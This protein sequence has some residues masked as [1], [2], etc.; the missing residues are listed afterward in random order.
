MGKLQTLKQ[1]REER[2]LSQEALHHRTGVPGPYIS[3]TETGARILSVEN[4]R[5]LER[6]LDTRI[7]WEDSLSQFDRAQILHS[8]DL[9]SRHFPMQAVLELVS[10]VLVNQAHGNP[11]ASLQL[12]A[13]AAMEQEVL[14]PPDADPNLNLRRKK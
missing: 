7:D 14:L 10:D 12:Y 4:M 2:G 11:A 9:L 6:E 3:H 1:A 5:A 8:I 13:S